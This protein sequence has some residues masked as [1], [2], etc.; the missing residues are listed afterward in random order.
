MNRAEKKQ[1]QK[2]EKANR[3]RLSMDNHGGQSKYARK[4]E[5]LNAHTRDEAWPFT[6]RE[7]KLDARGQI[8]VENG[9]RVMIE[10]TEMREVRRQLWGFEVASPKPWNIAKAAR[11]AA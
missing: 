4:K 7:P 1:K 9:D 3:K 8:V 5:W 11:K 2:V 10:R 6:V